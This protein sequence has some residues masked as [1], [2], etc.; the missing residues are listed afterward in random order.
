MVTLLH[1]QEVSRAVLQRG[2][3]TTVRFEDTCNVRMTRTSEE[4]PLTCLH[5]HGVAGTGSAELVDRPHQIV[6][7][8]GA[9]QVSHHGLLLLLETPPLEIVVV[10]VGSED[11]R[12]DVV[13]D[14]VN[15]L[16]RLIQTEDL[17]SLE[18]KD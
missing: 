7:T 12:A 10:E 2:Q 1:W 8:P 14:A 6:D 5:Q 3:L 13:P 15:G 17:L 18:H 9:L 4:P 11:V 16:D